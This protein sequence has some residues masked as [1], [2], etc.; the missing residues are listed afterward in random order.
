MELPAP[1]TLVSGVLAA[2]FGLLLPWALFVSLR[3][4]GK[5]SPPP[6]PPAEGNSKPRGDDMS[7]PTNLASAPE[8]SMPAPSVGIE[9]MPA[10]PP[11]LDFALGTRVRFQG[12]QKAPDLNGL[13]G[14]VLRFDDETQRYVVRKEVAR[15][16]EQAT[17]TL[18]PA[19]LCAVPQRRLQAELQE[20]LDAA[21]AGA[22]VTLAR[23]VVDAAESVEGDVDTG[24]A[25]VPLVINAAI[26]LVGMGSR[27]GGTVL[28]FDVEI[29]E[30]VCGAALELS[31][32]HING[33]LEIAPRDV[34]RVRLSKVAVT[35]PR[36]VTAAIYIDEIGTKIPAPAKAEGRVSLEECW[37]R[38]GTVGVYLNAVGCV[39]RRCR[40]VQAGT[41]GVR[42]N[43]D[44]TIE[45]CTIG[46]CAKSGVGG[47]GILTRAGVKEVRAANGFNE[48][49]VQTD[50]SDKD[51][52]GYNPD[53]N[54]C[55]GRCTC[56]ALP[57]IDAILRGEG[58][59][60]WAAQGQGRWQ[61]IQ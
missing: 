28:N 37:V 24:R 45:A 47:G 12:L 51:Y 26:A 23:G 21:P 36:K 46:D 10:P 49:R 25:P 39:L 8:I 32:L 19:N 18:K 42:A 4:S 13:H 31:G 7:M 54:G 41:F 29:G 52:S 53:C 16:G 5:R 58:L 48:N 35:A 17:I 43:A 27:S 50:A 6:A 59:I 40:V 56:M 3:R 60:K 20:L 61:T 22:R 14:I 33:T 2:S 44:F 57:Q 9:T 15:E 34:T 55:V 38:G 1:G 11:A 30:H